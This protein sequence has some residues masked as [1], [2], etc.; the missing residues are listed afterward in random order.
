[1]TI[2]LNEQEA[3]ALLQLLDLANKAAG[4]SVA[5][6]VVHF[7]D[8]INQAASKAQPQPAPQDAP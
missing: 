2:E 1:M 3:T 5:R 8:K 6:A 7:E 4:K